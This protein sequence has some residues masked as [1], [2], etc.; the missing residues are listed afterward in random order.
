[1][2]AVQLTDEQ[3]T[4]LITRLV[5]AAGGTSEGS[6][7]GPMEPCNLGIDK[8]KRLKNFQDWCKEAEAK[9]T[10][11]GITEDTRKVALLKSWAGRTLLNFWEKEARIQF[12]TIPRIEAA[13]G[14]E[15]VPEIPADT[16]DNIIKKTKA[17]LL[18]HVS[19]DR[20][21]T[22][23]LQMKQGEDTWMHLI[24]DVEDAADL[25]RLDTKPLTRED[26]IRVAALAGMRDRLLAE[27]VRGVFPPEADLGGHHQ[28]DL[29]SQ[30]GGHG[31]QQDGHH[32]EG[33]GQGTYQ[34]IN[35]CWLR[36]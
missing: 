25:C 32:Q 13:G 6:A 12:V 4:T 7:S 11:M 18:K 35:T 24:S 22:D 9:I 19:R 5:G 3:L 17:E 21:L 10:Y 16:F 26:A 8:V 20:S 33:S 28:G 2:A 27:K 31:G 14:Q 30:R 36:G 1:M 23:L 15:A 29:Q 34:E